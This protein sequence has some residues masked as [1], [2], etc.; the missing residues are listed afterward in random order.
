VQVAK[1]AIVMC[2]FSITVWAQ[3][4]QTSEVTPALRTPLMQFRAA[5]AS[6]N[7]FRPRSCLLPRRRIPVHTSCDKTFISTQVTPPCLSLLLNM[8][9]ASPCQASQADPVQCVG[10]MRQSE[11]ASLGCFS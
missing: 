4:T 1:A 8:R 6:H 10:Y 7:P 2:L 11:R 3:E 5:P 9:S